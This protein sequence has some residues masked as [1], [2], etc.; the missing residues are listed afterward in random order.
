[1]KKLI[2]FLLGCVCCFV[3]VACDN[4]NEHTGEAK[5]PSGSSMLKG[6]NYESVVNTFEHKGFTNIKLEK[7]EDLITGWLG[8]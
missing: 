4:S 1:M 7:I 8:R 3:L 6:Q 5:T 2:L